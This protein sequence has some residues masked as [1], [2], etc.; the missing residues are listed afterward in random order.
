MP[1]SQ[2]I[3]AVSLLTVR[4]IPGEH[5]PQLYNWGCGFA[6]ELESRN[7]GTRQA[8]VLKGQ[9]AA[10]DLPHFPPTIAPGV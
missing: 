9:C 5:K 2:I 4:V 7:A 3:M 1:K 8:A 10:Q 6:V